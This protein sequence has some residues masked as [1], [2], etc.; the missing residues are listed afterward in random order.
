[1]S[2][3][4]ETCAK[5]SVV[6]VLASGVVI[7]LTAL[8][9]GI[10]PA[11]AKPD[12]DQVVTT[13]S[14]APEPKV[15]APAVVEA[16]P[17][18]APPPKAPA[19][20]PAAPVVEAP[21]Q[22][23]QAVE[24]PASPVTPPPPPV[25][26]STTAPVVTAIAPAAP[27]T[28]VSPPVTKTDTPAPRVVAPPTSE[29]SSVTS[30]S[31]SQS[32]ATQSSSAPSTSTSSASATASV[33]SV[34]PSA[35]LV[36]PSSAAGDASSPSLAPVTPSSGSATPGNESKSS[37]PKVSAAQDS[38]AV[39][40][41]GGPTV[42]VTQAAKVIAMSE[43]QTLQAPK[44]DVELAS[45]VDPI[46][47]KADPAPKQDVDSFA[48][49][50]GLDL[51]VKGPLGVDASVKAD[52]KLTSERVPDRNIRQ[53]SPDWVQYDEYYRPIIL[54]P[55]HER[56]RVVYI[57]DY[58]PRIV[59]IPPLA[60]AVLDVAQ[61]AAYSF[62]AVVDTAANIVNAAVATAVDVA[63]GSF[64]GGGYIP[65]Y[66]QPLPPPPPPVLT[67]DNVPVLVNYSNAR[68]EPFRVRRIVD[69]GDDPQYGEHKVLLDGATP[70]WGEWTQTSSGERQFE[71]HKTQQYP[72]LDAP[73]QAPLPGDYQLRLAS[74]ETPAGTSGRD[75]FL[76]VAAGV[77][78]ALGFG[79]IALALLLGRRRTE[80]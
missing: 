4:F 54:N 28:P 75:A 39:N 6:A 32:P 55:Y 23:Q 34:P 20:Q 31:T 22:T 57:Y 24:A 7:S 5:R 50:I 25:T 13:T 36:P 65:A 35:A 41:T 68:Y 30:T 51:G 27:S 33:A 46:E 12:T 56:V 16:P 15:Q 67:Y 17:Q 48:T 63:V 18:E 9:G 79:A 53:W 38:S 11:F 45:K 72:G 80:H 8:T 43:P 60:R 76:Y 61:F 40:T 64:F 2:A 69:V 77:T 70:A 62:T 21:P 42:S 44:T 29:P 26:Q 71:V 58:Q 14:A 49:S 78:V 59:W 74:D 1:M 73:Q 37:E 66:G 10:A 47:V 52:A 3:P 19:P